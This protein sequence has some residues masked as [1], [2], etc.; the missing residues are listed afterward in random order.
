MDGI[1]GAGSDRIGVSQGCRLRAVEDSA[2]RGEQ[3]IVV[4]SGGALVVRVEVAPEESM[5]GTLVP[6][7]PAHVLVFPL[8]LRNRVSDPSAGVAGGRNVLQQVQ[9]LLIVQARTHEVVC[10]R[11]AGSRVD[12]GARHAGGLAVGGFSLAPVAI[13]HGLGGHVGDRRGRGSSNASSLVAEETEQLIPFDRR[14]NRAAELV[15]LQRVL[16]R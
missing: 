9:R 1:E 16:R 2:L 14:S 12:D 13:E 11:L 7:Y 8:R 6:I 4:E 3:E 5:L 10:E 15:S